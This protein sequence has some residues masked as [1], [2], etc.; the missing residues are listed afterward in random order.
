MDETEWYT[1]RLHHVTQNNVQFWTYE[2]FIFGTVYLILLEHSLPV[3][4]WNQGKQVQISIGGLL[5]VMEW[6][7]FY[8]VNVFNVTDLYIF[9]MVKIIN[10]MLYALTQ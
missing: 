1:G 6:W 7:W 8:K 10:I 9:Q 4:N 5:S 3:G 2:V